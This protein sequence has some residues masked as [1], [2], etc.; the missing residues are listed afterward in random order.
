[1]FK[2]RAAGIQEKQVWNSDCLIHDLALNILFNTMSCGDKF[3]HD[4]IT[5]F[6]LSDLPADSSTILYRQNILIDCLKNPETFNKMYNLC[7][8]AAEA[9]KKASWGFLSKGNPP[10]YYSIKLMD[11]YIILLKELLEIS[12]QNSLLFE[13]EG[14]LNLFNDLKTNL[15]NDFFYWA[16]IYLKELKFENG[17][18]FSTKI[19]INNKVSGFTLRSGERKRSGWLK[20]LFTKE[21]SVFSF[22]VDPR[23][24]SGIRALNTIQNNGLVDVSKS[25]AIATD[26]IMDFF[27]HLRV[28]LSFYLGCMNLYDKLSEMKMKTTFPIPEENNRLVHSFIGLYDLTLSLTMNKPVV[29]NALEAIDNEN[30]FIITGANKGGKSTFLRSIGVAQIMMQCGMFVPA[31]YYRA[32]ISSQVVTHFKK[33]EDQSLNSGKFDEELFRMSEMIDKIDSGALVLLNESF[34]STNVREGSE[35]AKQVI[36]AFSEKKMKVFFVTHLFD[37]AD[38]IY[39]ESCKNSLFLIAEREQEENRTYKII[40]GKPEPTSHGL[41][42]YFQIF[43][44]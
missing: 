6:I 9:K 42:L 41:D 5:G 36:K 44:R 8:E 26:H 38:S 15:D 13:S 16:E 18:S 33:E 11:D 35:I 14:F 21:K 7:L 23:D 4:T 31:E 43:N 22:S 39:R 24:D 29:S 40:Q 30:V 27:T 10:L 20:R 19:G 37:F 32:N 34:S 3:I 28:E 1:M 17:A 12:E 2:N 25:L